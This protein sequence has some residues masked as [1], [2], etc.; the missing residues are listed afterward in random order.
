MIKFFRKIRQKL[1]SE[2]KFSKYLIYAVGEIVLVVIGILIALQINNWNEIRKN[3]ERENKYLSNL[4]K[5]IINDSLSLERGWFNNRQKKI[6]SLELARSYVMG[7]YSPIDTLQFINIVGFGGI[8]SRASFIGSSRTYSEL[9]STGN[10]SSISNDSIRELIVEY[11]AG[12][13]F[14]KEYLSNIRSD[15]ATYVNGIK[16]YNSNYPDSINTIEIP[17]ILRKLKTDEFHSLIN[18][19]LTYTYSIERQLQSSKRRA[20]ILNK[21]I[22]QFLR[23]K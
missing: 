3:T 6:K 14:L 4:N 22:E 5:E 23:N 18:Q 15:Y 7:N 17:R 12:K 21:R 19:E 10:L 1:L 20:Y 16:V 11:Y 13:D 2:N 9:V 8:N